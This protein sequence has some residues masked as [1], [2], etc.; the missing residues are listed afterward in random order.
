LILL[1]FT[2]VCDLD[3]MLNSYYGSRDDEANSGN[4]L[5]CITGQSPSGLA[6]QMPSVFVG[7]SSDIHIGPRLQDIG[8]L[9]VKQYITVNG[10][11]AIESSYENFS[12]DI[13]LTGLQ[14]PDV[15]IA[16]SMYIGASSFLASR[17]TLKIMKAILSC[18]PSVSESHFTS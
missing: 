2:D 16:R 10:K 18:D 13:A 1:Y 14:P 5:A 3:A 8:Q 4:E 6:A 7:D 11:D 9:T 12:H 17:S 15:A